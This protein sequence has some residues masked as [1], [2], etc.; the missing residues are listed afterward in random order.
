MPFNR[1]AEHQAKALLDATGSGMYHKINDAP[2]FHGSKMRFT[3]P[4]PFDCFYL[5][6]CSAYVV[7][8]F[9]HPREKKEM[10]WIEIGEYIAERMRS[11]R[12]SLTEE[13]AREIGVVKDL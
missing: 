11:A 4:K 13:R 1:V 3:N 9:Y 12:K 5:K 2:I 8:W 10:I 6:R 7:L